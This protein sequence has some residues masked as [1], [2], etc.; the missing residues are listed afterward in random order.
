[1]VDERLPSWNDGKAQTAILEFVEQA[2]HPGPG[3]V[4]PADRVATFDNDGTLWCEKPLP[5]QLDFILRRWGEMAAADPKLR[6]VQPYK[7]VVEKDMAW[8]AGFES[9]VP[10]VMRGLGEAFLDLTPAQFEQQVQTF[11]ATAKHPRFDVP[12]LEVA[13]RPM[14]EL[15]QLLT[16]NDFRVFV[17]SGG[18]RDFMRVICEDA[19]GLHRERVIGTAPEHEYRDG[20]LH[21]TANMLGTIDNG[22]GKPVHIY[23]T[24][25][26]LPVLAAGNTD[27]DI[28]MLRSAQ[29][30]LLVHHDDPDREF[31][32]D[33]GAEQAHTAAQAEH[34]VVVSVKDDWNVV[35]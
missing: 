12:Y 35:F 23:D 5:V 11:F 26:R 7:A 1:V 21:R 10:E 17:A 13:Y 16:A 18:G 31:A 33:G 2:T 14:L 9:H 27:G 15:M 4:E 3:Y 20:E 6:E 8:L 32:Y 22:P 25:G 28:E 30:A 34:W 29:L 19:W 24:V